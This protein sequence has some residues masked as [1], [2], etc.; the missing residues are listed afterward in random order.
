MPPLALFLKASAI[1]SAVF[2][3]VSVHL[4]FLTPDNFDP[5]SEFSAP[6][7]NGTSRRM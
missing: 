3:G 1:G 5:N 7:R 4:S 6:A 2:F